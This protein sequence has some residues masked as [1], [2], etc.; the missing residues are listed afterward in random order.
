[1][2]VVHAALTTTGVIREV[3]LWV[4]PVCRLMGGW[5][6]C[7]R[8]HVCEVVV[9]CGGQEPLRVASG[10]LAGSD[11]R[12]ASPGHS[13]VRLACLELPMHTSLPY[14]LDQLS[15]SVL[16]RVSKVDGACNG[17]AIVDH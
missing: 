1:M 16:N 7:P 11:A 10:V 14:L 2:Q 13:M 5:E 9:V 6:M 17:H 12:P 3:C 8:S 15:S 4:H